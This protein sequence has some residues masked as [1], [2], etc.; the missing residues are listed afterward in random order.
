MVYFEH[1]PTVRDTARRYIPWN[2]QVATN[3]TCTSDSRNS[4]IVMQ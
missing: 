4:G 1:S 3:T 2:P